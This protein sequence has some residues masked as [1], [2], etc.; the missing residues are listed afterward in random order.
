MAYFNV[1]NT[2]P[3]FKLGTFCHSRLTSHDVVH[4]NQM[5]LT[6]VI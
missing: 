3:G 5:E 6:T 4:G 1:A 2:M